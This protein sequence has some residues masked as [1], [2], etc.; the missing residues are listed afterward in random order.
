MEVSCDGHNQRG[1]CLLQP[2]D[3]LT[4]RRYHAGESY[5]TSSTDIQPS[6]TGQPQQSAG[7]HRKICNTGAQNRTWWFLPDAQDD[8]VHSE[9]LQ[10]PI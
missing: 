3:L 5:G 6:A 8:D 4:V 9:A 2:K 7:D 10:P 1:R